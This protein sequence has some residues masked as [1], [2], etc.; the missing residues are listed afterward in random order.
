MAIPVQSVDSAKKKKIK[1]LYRK[2]ILIAYLKTSFENTNILNNNKII[3]NMVKKKKNIELNQYLQTLSTT[4][5]T[6]RTIRFFRGTP[7]DN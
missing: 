1:I 3:L 4:H 7:P 2:L 5:G 6:L